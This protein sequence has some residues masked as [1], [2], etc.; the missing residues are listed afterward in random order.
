MQGVTIWLSALATLAVF[1]FLYKENRIYRIA[2]HMLLGLGIGFAV[3]TNITDILLPKWWSPMAA[4]YRSGHWGVVAF[5]VVAGILGL[6]WYGLYFKKTIWFSRL[7][8]ALTIGAGAGVAFKA[9]INDKLPQ[10]VASFKPIYVPASQATPFNNSISNI[11][12]LVILFSVLSY[13]F[14]SY[15]RKHKVLTG[16]AGAGRV[17]LMITFGVF[18]GNTIMTRMSVFIERIWFLLTQWLRIGGHS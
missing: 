7:V 12:F 16:A 17:F 15:E 5:G 9:E 1:S 8:M 14:F 2:E 3:A 6:M 11:I 4:G 10:I 13:F 18:F